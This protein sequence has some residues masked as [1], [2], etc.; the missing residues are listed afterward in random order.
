MK[1]FHGYIGV[2]KMQIKPNSL[3]GR[4]NKYVVKGNSLAV[5]IFITNTP[6]MYYL[7]CITYPLYIRL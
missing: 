4:S 3:S 6:L 2:N 5:Y 1:A 7:P